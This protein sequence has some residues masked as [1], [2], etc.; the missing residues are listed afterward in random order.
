M[1]N[2]N[3][4]NKLLY[5]VFEGRATMAAAGG[6][7]T[8]QYDVR[9]CTVDGVC[10]FA[11]P[12]VWQGGIAPNCSSGDDIVVIDA[13]SMLTPTRTLV[14][15]STGTTACNLSSIYLV[16]DNLF[17]SVSYQTLDYQE[18]SLY[19]SQSQI[20]VHSP[21]LKSKLQLA[22]STTLAFRQGRSFSGSVYIDSGSVV[23]LND[24]TIFTV[25][26]PS[27]IQGQVNSMN[28]SATVV[29]SSDSVVLDGG[30]M[31][32][33][34]GLVSFSTPQSQI[35][36]SNS[37]LNFKTYGPQPSNITINSTSN[38]N[39]QTD[40]SIYLTLLNNDTVLL[41]NSNP[42]NNGTTPRPTF[43]FLSLDI[44][45]GAHLKV[46]DGYTAVV[47]QDVTNN[48]NM[49]IKNIPTVQ[50]TNSFRNNGFGDVVL[51]SID[52]LLING[53]AVKTLNLSN[54]NLSSIQNF[55][56]DESAHVFIRS[57]ANVSMS[58]CLV[59]FVSLTNITSLVVNQSR[60]AN[61]S[62]S[63]PVP[64]YINDTQIFNNAVINNVS[65]M[66]LQNTE[67]D[68]AAVSWSPFIQMFNSS[69]AGTVQLLVGNSSLLNMDRSS[70]YNLEK[71]DSMYLTVVI[72]N[73]GTSKLGS[74]S[75]LSL[76]DIISYP[77]HQQ[78]EEGKSLCKLKVNDNLQL[79]GNIEFVGCILEVGQQSQLSVDNVTITTKSDLEVS[80]GILIVKNLMVSTNSRVD[81][82]GNSFV[83]F[84]TI[85]I[86]SSRAHVQLKGNY[87]LSAPIVAT[88]H[89]TLYIQSPL[90]T[91]DG[92]SLDSSLLMVSSPLKCQGHFVSTNQ[93]NITIIDPSPTRKHK[94]QHKPQPMISALTISIEKQ[95]SINV[96]LQKNIVNPN[97]TFVL[98]NA[99][100][101]IIIEKDVNSRILD[102][103]YDASKMTPIF[104]LTNNTYS[105]FMNQTHPIGPNNGGNPRKL[106]PWKIALIVIGSFIGLVFMSL[107]GYAI[108]YGIKKSRASAAER[109]PLLNR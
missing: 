90:E 77:H 46:E 19:S 27:Y 93:A 92:I 95:S 100:S 52:N 21:I 48:G 98:L 88:N 16:G 54:I 62:E 103:S 24:S 76:T 45:E 33:P 37:K 82:Q 60:I 2:N 106:S 65:F 36:L 47:M 108:Y 38:I 6:G 9:N 107:I 79:H 44:E 78:G 72:L 1:N 101:G 99:T 10:N 23:S 58:N 71:I 35:I 15:V 75:F 69:V 25:I 97:D 51:D 81:L 41:L 66:L 73:H 14:Y 96:L 94:H 42:L 18:F 28:Q 56:T 59:E 91:R 74:K 50:I 29:I 68:N 49:T 102:P 30:S 85:L 84:E 87:S 64:H 5:M 22:N 4:N 109:S 61:C 70:I 17:F 80:S 53:L 11:T 34:N 83:F 63:A 57:V 86:D 89:S 67:I 26:A 20:S 7:T 13:T 31:Y 104:I 105:L 32:C 12:N 43:T 8:C 55:G 3:N 40:T 39:T